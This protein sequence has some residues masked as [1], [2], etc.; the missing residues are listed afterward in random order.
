MVGSAAVA[1]CYGRVFGCEQSGRESP[2]KM[3]VLFVAP[4]AVYI[5]RAHT[6]TLSQ[7][8][9]V[10][11]VVFL[12]A[13]A[14]ARQASVKTN[15]FLRASLKRFACFSSSLYPEHTFYHILLHIYNHTHARLALVMSCRTTGLAT[16][17]H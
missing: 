15:I 3:H 17:P 13:G 16:R 9:P 4:A 6:S 14:A 2:K 5:R 10:V 12:A 8:L 1:V 7:H 11:D